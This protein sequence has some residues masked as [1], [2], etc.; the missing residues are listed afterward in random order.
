MRSLARDGRRP[1]SSTGSEGRWFGAFSA[2][3]VFTFLAGGGS[4]PDVASLMFVRV[5][6]VL[7]IAAAL[8]LLSSTVLARAKSAL[9]LIGLA[10]ALAVVHLLPLPPALWAALPG[11]GRFVPPSGLVDIVWRPLSLTPD[12]T[13][14]ALLSLL[15]PAAAVLGAVAAG[16]AGRGWTARAL[17]LLA[18]LSAAL[19]VAQLTGGPRSP[20]RFY[21]VTNTG[22]AVGLFANRNHHAVFLAVGIVLAAGVFTEPARNMTAAAWRPWLAAA[23]GVFFF[24]MVAVTGSRAG[25]VLAAALS[26]GS[27]VLY[28]RGVVPA[29]RPHKPRPSNKRTVAAA[30]AG[31]AAAL[32]VAALAVVALRSSTADRLLGTNLAEEQRVVFLGPL[33]DMA[34]DFLPLGSGLGSFSSAYRSYE[35]FGQLDTTYLNHAHNDALQL[36]IEGGLPGVA[37]LLTFLWWWTGAAMRAWRAPDRSETARWARVGS[38]VTASLLVASVLDY[39]LRTPSLAALFAIASAWM[40]RDLESA[41][42]HAESA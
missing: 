16:R 26:V 4:R 2:L 7:F 6:A 38:L 34:R 15:P 24:V 27:L 32:A 36:V 3:L 30:V 41:S 10:A 18:I 11:H 40:L 25:L 17:L 13:L 33:I 37:L 29:A 5:A 19:G 9:I 8:L 42:E 28:R 21:D 31:V 23:S 1:G 22:F 20:L 14:N 12:L 39:P 35:P